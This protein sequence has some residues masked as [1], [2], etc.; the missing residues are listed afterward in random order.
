MRK[1]FAFN[2]WDIESAKAIID[3]SAILERPVLLQTSAKVFAGLDHELFLTHVR[4]YAARQGV[5]VFI[6][7]DHCRDKELLLQAIES[8]WDSVMVD[9]SAL[10]LEDNIKLT[11]E[12]T[13]IAHSKNIRVE[14]EVGHIKKTDDYMDEKTIAVAD[15]DDIKEFLH[16]TD[17]DLFAAA[18]GTAHGLYKG[19][20]VIHHEMIDQIAEL[21]DIPF[22]IH[23]GTGLTD[24]EF[25]RL[26]QHD[27]VRKINISTEVKQAYR[28]G[29]LRSIDAGLIK[30][31]TGAGF[32]AAKV[33]KMIYEEIKAMALHKMSL[34]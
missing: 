8:G 33:E 19:T 7:L 13:T 20:P 4:G 18:I 24:D 21:T 11:N 3:A 6:H 27:N 1:Y 16:H 26:L 28:I 2:I 15:M 23:G 17:V 9:A 25:R 32:E 34:L 29:I 10:P 30:A 22:V 31:E 14:A 12:M 5:E